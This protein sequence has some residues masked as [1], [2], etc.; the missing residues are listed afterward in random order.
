MADLLLASAPMTA[1]PE[2]VRGAALHSVPA[3]RAPT[4]IRS[5]APTIVGVSPSSG[6][7]SGAPVTI[8]GTHLGTTERVTFNRVPALIRSRSDTALRVLAPSL[9]H[10]TPSAHVVD[11]QVVTGSGEADACF[12]YR[13]VAV[14]LLRGFVSAWNATSDRPGSADA[15]FGPHALVPVLEAAGWPR[16]VFQDFSYNGGA[17]GREGQWVATPYG[18]GDTVKDVPGA[19]IPELREEISGYA[20]RHPHLDVY[21]VGH[22]QGG[23]IAMSYLASL[24]PGGSP[25]SIA[26]ASDAWLAGVITLDSPIGGLPAPLATVGAQLLLTYWRCAVPT[27]LAALPSVVDWER[28]AASA[29]GFPYGGTG[30]LGAQ[31]G[32]S[33]PSARSTWPNGPR[34][35][36]RW[37]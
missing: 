9:P 4:A 20:R 14:I 10:P 22:S 25:R 27:T 7:W 11:V 6:P 31:G 1:A 32:W 28:V 35:K 5:T 36:A 17:T 23:F 19:D 12:T 37:S 33:R 26:G 24:Y 15:F 8:S 18:C 16:G 30:S 13:G 34:A 3:F 2:H 21:L 29:A